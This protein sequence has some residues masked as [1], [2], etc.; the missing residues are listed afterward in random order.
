MTPP[1]RSRRIAA[2]SGV[3]TSLAMI[4]IPLAP[5]GGRLRRTMSSLVVTGLFVTTSANAVARWGPRR[6]GLA[7]GTIAAG[8][9]AVEALG[10]AT[11]Y[12]FGR[13]EYTR[14]LRPAI[15]GVPV[16]VPMA[17]FGM[18][19]PARETAHS[20]LGAR[21]NPASRTFGGA[22]ALAAWDLFLDPQM[23]GEGYWRWL[24]AGRYRGIPLSNYVGW[25][26]TGLAV[27]AVLELVLPTRDEAD[28]AMLG[29]YA[30]MGVME[31]VG[32]A[33]FFRDRTVAVVGGAAMLPLAA[34]AIARRG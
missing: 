12:P 9:A 30:F 2:A 23:V 4:A 34:I 27:M 5:Q 26:A 17:W 14:A 20:A 1:M 7:S 22:I 18:A 21:S 16:I 11:G 6:A 32:F 10:T 19:V 15:D 3:L 8:T 24:T 25:F 13:Y 31:T 33:A 28:A 29:E